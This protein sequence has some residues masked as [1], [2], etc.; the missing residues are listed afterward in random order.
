MVL[1]TVT[2]MKLFLEYGPRFHSLYLISDFGI[3]VAFGNVC[4]S[5]ITDIRTIFRKSHELDNNNHNQC[6]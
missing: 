2:A 4:F 3:S 6:V 5:V 1:V